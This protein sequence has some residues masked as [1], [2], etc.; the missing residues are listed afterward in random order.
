MTQ[1]LA[2][3]SQAASGSQISIM[4]RLS[5]FNIVSRCGY[6]ANTRPERPQARTTSSSISASSN[7]GNATT[8][9]ARN[10]AVFFFSFGPTQLPTAS[11]NRDAISMGSS[12][13]RRV[14]SQTTTTSIRHSNARKK[15]WSRAH[16]LKELPTMNSATGE[17]TQHVFLR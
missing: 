7:L 11:P 15:R 5:S 6:S 13:A 16:L 4:R 3:L 12:L 17:I 2:G 1:G 10:I 9:F 8:I 14:I